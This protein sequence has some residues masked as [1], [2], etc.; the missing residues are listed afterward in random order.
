MTPQIIAFIIVKINSLIF[1]PPISNHSLNNSKKGSVFKNKLKC[2]FERRKTCGFLRTNKSLVIGIISWSLVFSGV[3]L[4]FAT[5]KEEGNRGNIVT[6]DLD[7]NVSIE[8]LMVYHTA[9]LN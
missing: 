7:P 6:S 3:T 8:N 9:G 1:H 4:A 2:V 5:E